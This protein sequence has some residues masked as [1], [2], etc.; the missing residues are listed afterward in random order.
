MKYRDTGEYEVI[1]QKVSLVPFDEIYLIQPFDCGVTDYNNFLVHDARKYISMGISS[2]HLLI[3]NGT[4]FVLGYL[5]LLTDSFLLDKSEKEK[6]EL[7]IPFSSV[8]AL[9]IGKLATHK[10]RK[11]HHYGCY[12]LELAL[13]HAQEL[14]ENGIAC[15]FL[16][17][18][19]DIEFNATNPEFYERNGF[20]RNQHK[21]LKSRE[22]S[23]SMR[24]DIFE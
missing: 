13:G 5:A 23:V 9:K 22:H 8:P 6:M 17:L 21:T 4:D 3:E 19:A 24:Y 16:T 7:D 18:D 2:V 10:D 11:E 20:V 12:L 14:L 1:S 15:R